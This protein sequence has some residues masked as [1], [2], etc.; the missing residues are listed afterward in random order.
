[1]F[2]VAPTTPITRTGSPSRAIAP[3]AAT[4]GRAA[5]HVEL[6]LV[7]LRRGLDRDAAGVERDRL[8]DEAEH[9]AASRPGRRSAGRS[10]RAPSSAALRDGG[11]RAHAAASVEEVAAVR[12]RPRRP[13]APRAPR[14]RAPSGV[15]SLAGVFCRSR[16]RLAASATTAAALDRARRRRGGRRRSAPRR[17]RS[18]VAAA[19]VAVE[20]VGGEQRALDERAASRRR[21]R[22]G[23]A[24]SRAAG[25]RAPARGRGRPR[26]RCARARRRTRRAAPRPTS[27]Q[28]CP[29]AWAT[30]RWRKAVRASP[31]SSRRWSAPSSTSWATVSPSNTPTTSVSASVSAG[32]AVVAD[33]RMRPASIRD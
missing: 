17:A 12:P 22:G 32:E 30:A 31:A 25:A 15:R 6:H 33:T 13:R 28:R 27:S 14:R 26:P 5:R 21:R 10:A 4:H 20:A 11:E 1:M 7:H 16:A 19:L 3:T 18:S 8:A 24:P 29:A 9:R 23:A 2:S